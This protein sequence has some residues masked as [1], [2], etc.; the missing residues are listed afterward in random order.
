V[1]TSSALIVRYVT[2][3]LSNGHY[4]SL[5]SCKIVREVSEKDVSVGDHIVSS[6]SCQLTFTLTAMS[7]GILLG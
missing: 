6:Y 2:V 1:C 3:I 7:V 5:H 4:N